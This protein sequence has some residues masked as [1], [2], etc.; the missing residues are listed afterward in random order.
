M[1]TS[2][3][4]A[5][6]RKC[7]Y[8]RPPLPRRRASSSPPPPP[9]RENQRE[10]ERA[11]DSCQDEVPLSPVPQVLILISLSFSYCSFFCIFFPL[12][13]GKKSCIGFRSLNGR[14]E[15]FLAL[16][17]WFCCRSVDSEAILVEKSLEGKKIWLCCSF[18][19][20]LKT[21]ILV[22]SWHGLIFHALILMLLTPSLS[23]CN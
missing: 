3:R 14:I 20:F 21:W 12:V 15:A 13:A 9:S 17:C 10:R 22:V 16:I 5:Q 8:F 2:L 7:W 1:S 18:T 23:W 4:L 19:P 6:A 11:L